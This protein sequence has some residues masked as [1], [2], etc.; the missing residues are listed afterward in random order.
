[1]HTTI[2]SGFRSCVVLFWIYVNF[3]ATFLDPSDLLDYHH[4]AIQQLLLDKGWRAKKEKEEIV[5]EIL[6]YVRDDIAYGFSQ[7]HS[8]PASQVLT[9]G[10]GDSITKSIL[11]MALL[12]AVGV[13]CRFHAMTKNKVIFRG[14]LPKLSYALATRNPYCALVE[15]Q[16]KGSWHAV[17]RHVIDKSY[18]QNIQQK[19]P[20]HKRGFYGYGIA[21][22][23]F[24]TLAEKWDASPFSTKSKVIEEDFGY[25]NT[26]DTFFTKNPE[27]EGYVQSLIYKTCILPSLNKSM[28]KVRALS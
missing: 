5:L 18:I 3:F 8:I 17:E 25:F 28:L 26:P 16:H 7:K 13:P 1:M 9:E 19:Y 20:F 21:T 6:T 4:P 27:A 11:F 24:C 14:L 2:T 15:I 22:L 12:R 10:M 23:D